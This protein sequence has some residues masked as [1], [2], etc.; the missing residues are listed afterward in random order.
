M[1]DQKIG[2]LGGGQLGAMLLR[3][4]ID[5]GVDISVMDKD[6][7]APCAQYTSKFTSGDLRDFDA[8][9]NFGKGLD[10]I[11]IEIEAVNTDALARLQQEGVKVHPSPQVI[12]TIQDKHLQ[13]QFLQQH[14]LPVSPSVLI[15]S[16]DQLKDQITN[17]PVCL[18]LCRDGY[19][20]RGVMVLKSETDIDQAF[21]APSIL[22]E[23]VAID[24]ELAVIVARNESGEVVT[25]DPVAMIFDDK[26]HVLDYQLCPADI[27]A[28]TVTATKELA[29]KTAE[30]LQ[31]VGIM[32]VEMF[33]TKDGNIL[34]NEL[35]PRPH[36]SGHHSIEGCVTSQFEQHLRAIL[37]LPL[38]AT[39]ITAP[40][41]MLNLLGN[42]AL[43]NGVPGMSELLSK[44]GVHLHWYGKAFRTGRKLGH[45]TV[46]G[47]DMD[48]VKTIAQQVKNFLNTNNE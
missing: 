41:I 38:G 37:N 36:N 26:A 20:G 44:E 31:L 23:Y 25:Y 40:T 47:S 39:T 33:L 13:K 5:F 17:Y 30:A 43:A 4:A 22:E 18:K 16:K 12:S 24:Q 14:G 10:I 8:V 32:A 19:D 2:I 45:I 34:V 6:P 29:R 7:Q 21:D 46:R 3:S 28:Q 42:K 11:T 27:N 48:K 35:A 9:Y 15:N 1:K